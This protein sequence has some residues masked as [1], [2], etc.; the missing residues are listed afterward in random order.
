VKDIDVEDCAAVE[1]AMKD[2]EEQKE[3]DRVNE[4]TNSVVVAEAHSEQPDW[5]RLW[6]CG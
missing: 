1:G 4:T 2:T 3:K 5:R 6:R